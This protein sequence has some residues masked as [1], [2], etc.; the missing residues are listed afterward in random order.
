LRILDL[1]LAK[2]GFIKAAWACPVC[3]W[4]SQLLGGWPAVMPRIFA[5]IARKGMKTSPK[6]SFLV[7]TPRKL[8]LAVVLFF[9]FGW[10]AWPKAIESFMTDWYP[11]GFPL[12]IHAIG[13]CPPP[14]DCIDFRL[15]ALFID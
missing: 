7:P 3:W 8:I 15:A 12:V 13:F 9:I 1:F 4:V 5:L 6:I 2:T 14:G 10:I 11:V